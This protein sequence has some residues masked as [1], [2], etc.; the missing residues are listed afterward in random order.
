LKI[1]K[2]LNVEK[3]LKNYFA[4]VQD[5]VLVEMAYQFPYEFKKMCILM[6]LDLQIEKESYEK[7]NNRNRGN[8][9]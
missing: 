2:T 8:V 9:C 5:E 3:Y 6:C 7:E 1:N 4:G